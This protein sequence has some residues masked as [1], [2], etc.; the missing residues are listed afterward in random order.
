MTTELK[1]SLDQNMPPLENPVRSRK[2]HINNIHFSHHKPRYTA[3]HIYDD[4]VLRMKDIALNTVT[5]IF[6]DENDVTSGSIFNLFKQ[7]AKN[8]NIRHIRN[9]IQHTMSLSLDEKIKNVH[10]NRSSSNDK[11]SN[12]DEDEDEDDEEYKKIKE[13]YTR[14]WK[15]LLEDDTEKLANYI[16]MGIDPRLYYYMLSMY[17]MN[18]LTKSMTLLL[19]SRGTHE[20]VSHHKHLPVCFAAAFGSMESMMIL[21]KYGFNTH[22]ESLYPLTL[23]CLAGNFEVCE[24]IIENRLGSIYEIPK[25]TY[26]SCCLVAF[27]CKDVEFVE[28]LYRNQLDFIPEPKSHRRCMEN[29]LELYAHNNFYIFFC[30]NVV[31]DNMR[32]MEMLMYRSSY[33]EASNE[34]FTLCASSGSFKMT[35]YLL[36]NW[37]HNVHMFSSAIVNVGHQGRVKMLKY[38]IELGADIFPYLWEIFVNS[39]MQGY[40]KMFLYICEN[41]AKEIYERVFLKSLQDEDIVSE[42]VVTVVVLMMKNGEYEC[43]ETFFEKFNEI[44]ITREMSQRLFKY[45]PFGDGSDMML[46]IYNM[47]FLAKLGFDINVT[48]NIFCVENVEND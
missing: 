23:A 27:I 30:I 5:N 47:E 29:G 24:F 12:D 36:E 8:H 26:A 43:I 13:E 20:D 46:C 14:F 15:D 1:L 44:Q 18:G 33:I 45:F 35:K 41:Y 48:T 38:L 40:S 39:A 34:F 2:C 6:S 32:T 22:L 21:A 31:T 11:S 9:F 7:T 25:M 4:F 42:F 28:Y 16:N 19:D 10:H 17:A 3:Y 37:L